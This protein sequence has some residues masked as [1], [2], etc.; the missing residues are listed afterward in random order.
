MIK[1]GIRHPRKKERTK[2]K[3]SEVNSK[4]S[5]TLARRI[6]NGLGYHVHQKMAEKGGRKSK[7]NPKI[8]LRM[9]TS[10]SGWLRTAD[11]YLY[12][13]DKN[14]MSQMMRKC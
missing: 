14:E 12:L 7:K 2:R 10:H 4:R 1:L 5:T 11:V 6:W 13:F 8:R 3:E 9:D